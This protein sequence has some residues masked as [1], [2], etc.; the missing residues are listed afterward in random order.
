MLQYGNVTAWLYFEVCNIVQIK[1]LPKEQ[2][3]MITLDAYQE[4]YLISM[5]G[6]G[7][8]TKELGKICLVQEKIKPELLT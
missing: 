4:Y 3:E 5:V 1:N 8:D 6:L 2:V 7:R